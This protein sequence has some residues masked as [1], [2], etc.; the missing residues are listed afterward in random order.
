MLTV[1]GIG[2]IYLR[3]NQKVVGYSPNIHATVV[4]LDIFVQA[5]AVVA[6]RIHSWVKLMITSPLA[7][8][9]QCISQFSPGKL[10][11]TVDG[12]SH[13]YSQLVNIWRIRNC[14]IL[15][16]K[17]NA[18]ITLFPTRVQD[19]HRKA[20]G[21]RACGWLQR[22]C[23]FLETPSDCDSMYKASTKSSKMKIPTSR[24]R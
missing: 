11:L 14:G 3:A 16:P 24:G 5:I 20:V 8:V 7:C 23:I 21:A 12:N 22:N 13:K 17:W 6:L 4:P 2:G 18:P 9:H 10:Q 1:P 19:L 15:N